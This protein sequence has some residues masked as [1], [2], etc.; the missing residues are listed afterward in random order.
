MGRRGADPDPVPA[1]RPSYDL[2]PEMSAPRSPRV[3][4][5]SATATP[6]ASSTSRTRTWSGTRGDP[7]G[8]AAVETVDG[9]LGEVVEATHRAGGVCLV[10]ADHGNAEKLLEDDGSARTPPTRRIRC[11][12]SSRGPTSPA[13][14][15]ELSDLAPTVLDLLG[16]EQP[17]R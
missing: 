4:G 2:K 16:L 12:S 1:R 6:S 5:P 9:C 17:V 7:R 10:T 8:R 15:G 13:E 11:R 3:A 14:R